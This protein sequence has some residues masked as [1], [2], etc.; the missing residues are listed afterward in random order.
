MKLEIK[1]GW[2]YDSMD[3]VVVRV[4][5]YLLGIC[6]YTVGRVVRVRGVGTESTLRMQLLA[7]VTK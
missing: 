6:W 1:I 2:K 7:M 4:V 3:Q 5:W